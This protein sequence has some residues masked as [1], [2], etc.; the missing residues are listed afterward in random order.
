MKVIIRHYRRVND[1]CEDIVYD[2]GNPVI[3]ETVVELPVKFGFGSY[4]EPKKVL[5]KGINAD[6]VLEIKPFEDE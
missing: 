4:N 6:H 1:R 2:G 3:D 5:N